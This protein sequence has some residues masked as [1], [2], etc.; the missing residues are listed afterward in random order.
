MVWNS[1]LTNTDMDS[2]YDNYLKPRWGLP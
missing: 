2:L 1:F